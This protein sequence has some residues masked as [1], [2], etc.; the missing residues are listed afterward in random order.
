M[1]EQSKSYMKIETNS[2]GIMVKVSRNSFAISGYHMRELV[3]QNVKMLVDPKVAGKHDF[4]IQQYKLTKQSNLI[5]KKRNLQ[6]C[7][8]GGNMI[9]VSLQVVKYKHGN[10]VARCFL[11]EGE[12]MISVRQTG[13]IDSVSQNCHIMFGFTGEEMEG[14]DLDDFFFDFAP[15]KISSDNYGIEFV[16]SVLCKDKKHLVNIYFLLLLFIACLTFLF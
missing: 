15:S 16:A 7:T 14:R 9:D 5:G 4:F 2:D 8:K 10:F 11:V 12:V 13:K 1:K 6:L 3:G